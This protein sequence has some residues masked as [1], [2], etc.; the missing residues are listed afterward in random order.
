DRGIRYVVRYWL[1]SFAD[2]AD[3]RDAVLS[4]IDRHLRA[5][6]IAIPYGRERVLL[7]QA[8]DPEAKADTG[9][10]ETLRRLPAFEDLEP[11]V[12]HQLGRLAR[13]LVVAAGERVVEPA[14]QPDALFIV[15]EGLL[16]AS[17]A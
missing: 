4:A 11:E 6:G 8:P 13:S 14:G 15:A 16:L 3:C 7:E 1:P 12:L 9:S 2:E 17:D 5:A 10:A